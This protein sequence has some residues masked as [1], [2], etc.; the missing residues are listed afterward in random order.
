MEDPCLGL[1]IKSKGKSWKEVQNDG[2]NGLVERAKNSNRIHEMNPLAS[3]ADAAISSDFTVGITSISALAV[4]ALQGNRVI[5]LDYERVD[6]GPQKNYC[7]LHSL[8][9]NRCVFYEAQLLRQAITD[10]FNNP[11]ANP[12]LGNATPI[13]DKIDPFRDGK[14]SQRIGE[15][16]SS[17][18]EELD[19]GLSSDDAVRFA[20]NQF[21]EKWGQDKIVRRL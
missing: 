7:I 20:T 1:L 13:L 4:A 14:A 6:Q 18:L 2:L 3:P 17:Y 15:F 8:G 11:A 21:A 9:S 12:N 10:Y 19:N 16:V 5:Y